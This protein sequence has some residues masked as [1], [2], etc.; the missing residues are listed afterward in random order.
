[1]L[2]QFLDNE[3]GA[4]AIE[5]AMIALL[6]STAIVASVTKIGTTLVPI[7]NKVASYV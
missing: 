2:R 1:M 4:T 6:I 7:F 5:Y 3:S